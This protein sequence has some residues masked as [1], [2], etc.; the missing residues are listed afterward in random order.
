M[1]WQDAPVVTGGG[2][3][4]APLAD[5]APPAAAP[6]VPEG[7]LAWSDVPGQAWSNLGSSAGQFVSDIAQPFIH[8]IDTATNLGHVG[9]GLLQKAGLMSG[10]DS[11]KYADAIGQH[12][13]E[14]Y[15]S[16]EGIKRALATDPVG[17]VGDLSTVLSGGGGIAAKL[18]GLAGKAGSLAAKAGRLTDPLNV[19]TK[20]VAGATWG[21]SKLASPLLGLTTGGIGATTLDRARIAGREGGDASAALTSQM[22]RAANPVEIVDDAR[23]AAE[24]LREARAASYKGDMSALRT[25]KQALSWNDVDRALTRMG[26]VATFKGNVFTKNISPTTAGIRQQITNLVDEWKRDSK[27][28]PELLTPSGFDA[29][30][31]TIGN[32]RDAT[33]YG[34]PERKVADQAYHAVRKTIA[35]QAP[36][37]GK[38]MQAYEIASEQIREI[39]QALKLGNRS[40]TDAALRSLTSSLR[41]NVNTNFGRR[42]QLV[43]A[44][45]DAGAPQLTNKI[46]GSSLSS[47]TPRGIT[48]GQAAA[49]LLGT[50]GASFL[51]GGLLPL[52]ALAAAP[53]ASPR[54]M[55]EAFHAVGAGQR[56]GHQYRPA[57]GMV[58]QLDSVPRLYVSPNRDQ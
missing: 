19:V 17:V 32:I 40:S 14:R 48:G 2:W 54:A 50:V 34:T 45:Q 41:N 26:D 15:G 52:K 3:Q 4:N 25:D 44:L 46:A 9:A 35:D 16:E 36:A 12:F 21:A 43:E 37:Y 28:D 49:G 18:P 22:R 53:L 58:R 24:Q 39:E 13:A 8:P 20:P 6:A 31:Q 10:E 47:W 51:T 11:I 23:A 38:T 56:L 29:L 5:E 57:L 7:P 1:G 33:P 55:G 30:K 42:E 27:L